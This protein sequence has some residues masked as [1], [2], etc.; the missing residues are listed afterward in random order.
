MKSNAQSRKNYI[1]WLI[2][3]LVIYGL[4][5]LVN[6]SDGN[7][8]LSAL[9]FGLG[10]VYALLILIAF[11]ISVLQALLEIVFA[12]LLY[13]TLN[14]RANDFRGLMTFSRIAVR[15][16]GVIIPI[17]DFVFS[18]GTFVMLAKYGL[19]STAVSGLF[20][21]LIITIIIIC[22]SL[23]FISVQEEFE[24]SDMEDE[25]EKTGRIRS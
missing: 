16:I 12:V 2:V 10:S 3:M 8:N 4:R 22:V 24:Y 17:I 20:V 14:K 19:L 9:R 21:A 25:Y 11:I 6:A 23:K 5:F 1:I 15:I 7:F 18:I 13:N